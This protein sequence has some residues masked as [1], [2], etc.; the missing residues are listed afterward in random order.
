MSAQP[1]SFNVMCMNKPNLESTITLV[2]SKKSNLICLWCGEKTSGV[3]K[4]DGREHIFP[5]AIGGKK[6]LY[7]GA[8]C[9]NCNNKKLSFLDNA[10]KKEHPAMMDSYQVDDGIKGKKASGKNAKE[11]IAR[12][13]K[14]KTDIQGIGEASSTRP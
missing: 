10:L 2:N 3:K 12:R 13:I 9:E 4:I 5:E 1:L 8:V 11:K 14:E 7:V 6:T